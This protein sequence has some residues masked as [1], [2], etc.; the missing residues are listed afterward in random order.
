[1]H[2]F[3]RSEVKESANGN[4]MGK[5]RLF[6]VAEHQSRKDEAGEHARASC[7]IRNQGKEGEQVTDQN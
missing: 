4:I 2:D 3:T 6:E 7:S 1:M 5:S